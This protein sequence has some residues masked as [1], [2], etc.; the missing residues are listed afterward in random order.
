MN[1]N[2]CPHALVVWD[3][4]GDKSDPRNHKFVRREVRCRI[5]HEITSTHMNPVE[6]VW[7]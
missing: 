6:G 5:N 7:K 1:W 4:Q 2:E 3:E